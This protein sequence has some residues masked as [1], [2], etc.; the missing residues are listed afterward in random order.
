VRLLPALAL[1]GACAAP[2]LTPAGARVAI[3]RGRA[4]GAGCALV[5]TLRG[6][7]GYN[8]RS[9]ETNE[10]DVMVYLRNQAAE[11]GGDALVITA[12][13]L[14]ATGGDGESLSQPRGAMISGGC[15]N[16]IAMTASAYRCP[17]AAAAASAAPLPASAR[18]APSLDAEPPFAAKAAD[19][20][21]AA[22][23]ESARRCRSP[24][25]PTGEAR[26]KVTFAATGDVVYSE[27]ESEPFAGSPAGECIA[28]KFRNARVPPFAGEARSLT[29]TV[30]LSDE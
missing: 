8:G 1:L 5:A 17:S 10:A 20:A 28:R 15:P 2:P 11:R 21:L 30:R 12:R 23:A 7:A 24:G 25:G 9:G 22:A 29:T 26:V 18:P 3:A 14:G 4:P 27:V 16:C 6:S 19:A 13:Q